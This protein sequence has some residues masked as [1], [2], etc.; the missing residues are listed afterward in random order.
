MKPLYV[1]LSLLLPCFLLAKTPG[2]RYPQTQSSPLVFIENKGQIVNQH[3]QPRA[4]IQFKL[5]APGLDI[6]I[7]NGQIHYQ[8]NKLNPVIQQFEN[9]KREDAI[10]ETYRLDATLL[11]ANPHAAVIT[12]EPQD[13]YERY[14]LP[15]CPD[16]ITAHSFQRIIYK[17]IYPNIDWVIYI[18][19]G[20][21]PVRLRQPGGQKSKFKST[22]GGLKYD[23]VIHP[24][25][26]TRDI[27]IQYNGATSLSLDNGFLTA[28][29]PLG[30]ITENKPY[31][32]TTASSSQGLMAHD[33]L[34]EAIASRFILKDNILSFDI[35]SYNGTLVI[36][37]QLEWATYYGGSSQEWNIIRYYYHQ[38]K[39]S[40]I[41]SDM[42][43]DSSGNIYLTGS[44][45][46]GNNI[47]TDST[48]SARIN[49]GFDAFLA[50]FNAR[51]SRLWGTYY[52]GENGEYAM[53]CKTDAAGNIYLSGST[54]S[55]SGIATSTGH[56]TKIAGGEDGFLVKFD[57]NGVRQWSTYYGTSNS[58]EFI[59][60]IAT[61]LHQ[62][63]YCITHGGIAKFS[64]NGQ[65]VWSRQLITHSWYLTCSAV[66][67]PS[68]NVYMTGSSKGELD[69]ITQ[70]GHQAV[71]S[72][73][74]DG[75]LIKMN[76]DSKILWGTY[77]GG[78]DDDICGVAC[79]KNGNVYI[80]GYSSSVENIATPGTFSDKLNSDT[81][82]RDRAPD[83]FIAKFDSLGKRQW[84][85]YF[86]S[87]N[88]D[89]FKGIAIDTHGDIAAIGMTN[90]E[91]IAT[92]GC[93]KA[94]RAGNSDVMFVKFS[95]DGQ[96]LWATYYGGDSI[97]MPTGIA[98]DKMGDYIFCGAT[99]SAN[100]IATASSHHQDYS[101]MSDL[102][103]VK[104]LY[105]SVIHL[106]AD[107]VFCLDSGSNIIP[108]RYFVTR[109]FYPG[110]VFTVQLSDFKGSFAQPLNIGQLSSTVS[111]TIICTLP[112]TLTFRKGY[113]VRV[114][115]SSPSYI[116]WNNGHSIEFRRI[117]A[118]PVIAD[119]ERYLCT[120]ETLQISATC[121]TKGVWL[122]WTGPDY[123]K[124]TGSDVTRYNISS[125]MTGDYIITAELSGCKTYDTIR[126]IVKH[127]PKVIAEN[128]SPLLVGQTLELYATFDSIQSFT[129]DG[130]N[131]FTSDIQHIIIPDV[132]TLSC[133]RLHSYRCL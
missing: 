21:S 71:Y 86:G 106:V 107:T 65:F 1:I 69:T 52:G 79:D 118:K 59:G 68:G 126:I 28:A 11:N 133:R 40:S 33:S 98:T 129:W 8:W 35:A 12:E 130:P 2:A 74:N 26:N 32:Y 121:A 55:D 104:S 4:D 82:T 31:S 64:S 50:K 90:G 124:I 27:Q 66:C 96:R 29:T 85:T 37:P 18:E 84:G 97:D 45:G 22:I 114:I 20:K 87:D 42:D 78:E 127:K 30:S 92:P 72:G 54:S 93:W 125:S 110:N 38:D 56:Q 9:L 128:N 15:Q 34:Q 123:F 73:K 103:I 117:H 16:G 76:G 61:D 10:Y 62:G 60:D 7:G 39:I 6:F 3:Y 109:T 111:D 94:K 75:F 5:N 112:D 48:H 91:D 47:A 23:F 116:S 83:A 102:F 88:S 13:Y 81:N 100:G 113:R 89:Y 43:V 131:G 70:G 115:A 119:R 58:L 51:G 24:G 46:S 14:Y 17:D 80:A 120:G 108:I 132:Q 49:G 63:I 122:E 19:E 105:D 57:S 41:N 99:Y 53:G 95:A 44:T 77:Y 101:G 25:G 67:D 36:D